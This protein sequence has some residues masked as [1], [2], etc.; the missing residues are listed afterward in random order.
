MNDDAQNQTARLPRRA[1]SPPRLPCRIPTHKE[2]VVTNISDAL[3]LR[4]LASAFDA[5]RGKLPVVGDRHRS[6]EPVLV[7]RQLGELNT[8]S[9]ELADEVL[10]RTDAADTAPGA[11]RIVTAFAS[12]IGPAG[13]ASAALGEV[14]HQLAFLSQT[15][16]MR[17]KPDVRDVREAA[18]HVIEDSLADAE[19]ALRDAADVLHAESTT[20]AQPS[21]RLQAARARSTV[22]TGTMTTSAPDSRPAQATAT[23]TPSRGR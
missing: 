18:T 11:A 20:I 6:P 4:A 15:W 17:D 12:A 14:S 3:A 1:R 5:Q 23:A 10:F 9:T 13:R 22:A 8:L 21:L 16:P 2:S 7:A 19:S